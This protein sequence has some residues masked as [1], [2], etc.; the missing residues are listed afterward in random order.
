MTVAF[1][2]MAMPLTFIG[3]V[4]MNDL[5][6]RCG[7]IPLNVIRRAIGSSLR[8]K[9]LPFEMAYCGTRNTVRV[10]VYPLVVMENSTF[11]RPRPIAI[12]LSWMEVRLAFRFDESPMAIAW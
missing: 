4:G 10:D 9:R 7:C 11:G 12:N 8:I 6:M 3:P 2:T 5:A 1:K